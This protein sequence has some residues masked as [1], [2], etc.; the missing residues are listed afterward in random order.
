MVRVGEI[1]GQEIYQS[2]IGSSAN[3][4]WR[5]FAVAA[6]IVR[7]KVVPSKLSFDINPTSRQILEALIADGRLGALV[8]AGARVHQTGC[9]GCIGMGQAPAVGRNSLRTTPRN[10]PGRS[11]TE[12][13]FSISSLA[14]NSGCLGALWSDHRSADAWNSLSTAGLSRLH[15]HQHGLAGAT[16]VGPREAG[17]VE[18]IKGPNIRS[19]P[20]FDPL[21]DT[22]AVPI[23]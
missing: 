21:P 7:G 23:F 14:G 9:N 5:D 1:E 22:L 15:D 6:E 8:A 11:G 12:E 2:Y 16:A 17:S 13:D 4:G 3:P 20:E 19:L 10:F 18:L